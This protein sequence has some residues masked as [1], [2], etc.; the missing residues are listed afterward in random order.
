[1]PTISS[2]HESSA[3]L[4]AACASTAAAAAAAT[5]AAAA[6]QRSIVGPYRLHIVLRQGRD[7][8]AKDT[9]GEFTTMTRSC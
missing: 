5:A 3:P 9:C 4:L 6:H 1:M 2:S 8:A 7:L